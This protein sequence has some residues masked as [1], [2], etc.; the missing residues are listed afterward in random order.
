MNDTTV[1]MIDGAVGVGG[2]TNNPSPSP[3][4]EPSPTPSTVEAPTIN[5]VDNGNGTGTVTIT[6]ESGAQIR[7]TT[8]G[9]SVTT[10]SP[11]YSAPF[12]VNA[13]TTTVKAKA[14]KDGE[15]SSEATRA[16]TVEAQGGGGG[17][18]DGTDVD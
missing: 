17:G 6:A 11:L 5:G 3:S 2:G 12:S 13:G 16:I 10:S 18:D 15:A 1:E 8:D 4:P 14:Y 7:Y 9:S